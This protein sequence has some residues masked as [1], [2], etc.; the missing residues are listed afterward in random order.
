MFLKDNGNISES[1]FAFL[2]F[3]FEIIFIP[4]IAWSFTKYKYRTIC[5]NATCPK[6]NSMFVFDRSARELRRAHLKDK[7]YLKDHKQKIIGER[8]HDYWHIEEEASYTCEKCG[9]TIKRQ[10]NRRETISKRDFKR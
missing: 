7:K 2:F 4:I 10:E 9:F 5:K 6:C 1:T 8:I 3:I